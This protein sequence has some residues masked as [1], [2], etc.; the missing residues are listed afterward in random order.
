MLALM[1]GFTFAMALSRFDA[2]RDALMN[3]ANAIGTA[4]LRARLLPSP[5]NEEVRGLLHEYGEIRLSVIQN[6]SS[7]EKARVANDRSNQIREALWLATKRVAETEKGIVPV[8]V[9]VQ[10]VNE[11]LDSQGR[12]TFALESGVPNAVFW[13]LYGIGAVAFLFV[14]YAN[15]LQA[16]S[17]RVP[18]YLMAAVVS[19]LILLIQDLDRPTVG[20][21]NVDQTPMIDAVRDIMSHAD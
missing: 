7:G 8:G 12:H 4:A 3:E 21:I 2:R 14:G 16:R 9:F 17:L 18:V 1:I 13:A 11:M 10:A 15:R 20:F 19:G 5:Y 6:A